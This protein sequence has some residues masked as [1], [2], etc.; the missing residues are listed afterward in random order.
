M[1]Q[2]SLESIQGRLPRDREKQF[3]IEPYP[4]ID[5]TPSQLLARLQHHGMEPSNPSGGTFEPTTMMQQ[6]F[7]GQQPMIA[8]GV[9][10]AVDNANYRGEVET[11]YMTSYLSSSEESLEGN[12]LDLTMPTGDT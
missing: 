7:M 2:I 9:F 10:S 5:E 4:D 11:N 6:R 8:G 3:L 12:E 1:P